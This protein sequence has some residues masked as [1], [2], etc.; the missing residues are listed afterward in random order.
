M[1]YTPPTRERIDA[2]LD[3]IRDVIAEHGHAVQGVFGVKEGDIDFA[4]TV[5]LCAREQAELIVSGLGCGDQAT[6]FLNYLA[7]M[8]LIPGQD[9][10]LDNGYVMKLRRVYDAPIGIARQAYGRSDMVVLQ[11][12]WPDDEHRYPGDD[13]YSGPPQE[14]WE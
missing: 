8:V 7:S 11:V 1:T 14:L 3:E 9:L 6:S 10:T 13:D 2:Y 12:I 5:G 4:Y